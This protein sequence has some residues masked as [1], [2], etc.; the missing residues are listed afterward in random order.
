MKKADEIFRKLNHIFPF[1][2]L[3]FLCKKGIHDY[4]IQQTIRIIPHTE[5]EHDTE[6]MIR[7]KLIDYEKIFG[8]ELRCRRCGEIKELN[9]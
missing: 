1:S 5:I 9:K 3:K 8:L 7:F 4:C 6:G 2:K